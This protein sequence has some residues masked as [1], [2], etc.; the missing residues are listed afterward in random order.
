MAGLL[1]AYRAENPIRE[2]PDCAFGR[3]ELELASF[4]PSSG[5]TTKQ[6]GQWALKRGLCRHL[7]ARPHT[8]CH[9]TDHQ[10]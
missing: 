6:F 10:G 1:R 3:L 8:R 9:A 7:P 4:G 5:G 2:I